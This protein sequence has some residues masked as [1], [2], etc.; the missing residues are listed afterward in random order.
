MVITILALLFLGFVLGCVVFGYK[1][2]IKREP[3]PEGLESEKCS[4][5]KGKFKKAELVE[6][7]IGD[8][9]LMYF[10]RKCIAELHADAGLRN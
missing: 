8:Y 3:N 6:R 9:K 4:V 7:Q 5:C 1:A 10:C 2:V